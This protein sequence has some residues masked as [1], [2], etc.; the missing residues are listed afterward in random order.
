MLK[1]NPSKS[2]ERNNIKICIPHDL[3]YSTEILPLRREKVISKFTQE[4]LDSCWESLSTAIIQNYQRGKGTLIKDFGTFTFKG[5]EINLEGTTNEIF[6]DKKE[7]LPVFLVSK[8]FNENLKSG[9]YTKQYGIRYYTNKENKNIPISYINYSE[10]AFSLSMT[11]DRVAEIIKHLILFIKESIIQKK[12]K[13]KIMPGLG[14]LMLKQNILAVKFNENFEINIKPKNRKMNIL[15]S[16]YSLDMNFDDAKD[17]D[18]GN[19]P[20]IYQTAENIKATN[21]LMTEC[22]QSAKN[23]LNDNYNIHIINSSTNINPQ[24]TFYVN[25]RKKDI[26]YK[27]NFFFKR[28]ILLNF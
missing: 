10:I 23:Y 25:E 15:K 2:Q 18:M 16:K 22:Q 12:F 4:E 21:S 14:V 28:V 13:N 5:T 19:Y 6:R 3:R 17:L 11:K 20:S 9:E 7:R 8:E 1:I 26:F 27:N 24:N